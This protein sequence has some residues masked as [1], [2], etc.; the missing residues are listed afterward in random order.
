MKRF[1]MIVWLAGCADGGIGDSPPM[2]EPDMGA[3]IDIE[4]EKKECS[5]ANVAAICPRNWGWTVDAGPEISED[6]PD[7]VE[8]ADVAETVCNGHGL[9]AEPD[10]FEGAI[11]GP[12]VTI[13]HNSQCRVT[14][15]PQCSFTSVC[16]AP[17]PGGRG[18]GHSCEPLSNSTRQECEAF[19]AECIGDPTACE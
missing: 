11:G 5:L 16:Y 18:C 17:N 7:F 2:D 10:D 8:L 19:V 13:V 3:D 1:I 14:C 6:D 12:E 4:K 9:F 15:Y